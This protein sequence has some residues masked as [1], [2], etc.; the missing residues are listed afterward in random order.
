[1]GVSQPNWGKPGKFFTPNKGK[2]FLKKPLRSEPE[3]FQ[4]GPRKNRIG[5]PGWAK[6]NQEISK[7]PPVLLPRPF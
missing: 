7:V 3:N 5:A 1:L 4:I 2:K 6:I